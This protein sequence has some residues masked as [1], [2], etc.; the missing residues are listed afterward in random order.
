MSS[1]FLSTRSTF[2][3]GSETLS[4]QDGLKFDSSRWERKRTENL[5]ATRWFISRE[6]DVLFVCGLA[7]WLAG[8]VFFLVTGAGGAYP[9]TKLPQ[10]GLTLFF[11]VASLIIGESHQFTS[12]VRYYS[13]EFRNRSKKYRLHRVP[14][15]FLYL[16]TV[17]LLV[18]STF[19]NLADWFSWSFL[20]QAIILNALMFAFPAVLMQHVCAQASAVV[21]QYCRRAHYNISKSEKYLLDAVT[22]LLVATGACSIAVPFGLDDSG[23]FSA[24]FVGTVHISSYTLP[25]AVLSALASL[26]VAVYVVN[27]GLEKNNWPP[28]GA[29]LLAVNCVALILLAVPL[30]GMAYVWLFVPLFFHATQHWAL[31]WSTCQRESKR[32]SAVPMTM[33]SRIV[34][35]CK[36]IAPMMVLTVVVL[37]IPQF[38]KRSPMSF[39]NIGV[40]FSSG[41]SLSVF[42]SMAVFYAHYFADRMVWRPKN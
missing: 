21:Q 31:A 10:Q 11:V 14:I 17:E 8:I 30:P 42:F 15:W 24:P 5:P 39:G 40:I 18:L 23:G 3:A 22:W 16:L 33:V 38:L 37:F 34:D 36:F 12:I 13:S 27:R 35:I 19:N 32:D 25:L 4:N 20:V 1:S 26:M 29:V 6:I 41:E 9:P 2:P 28:L 7:P